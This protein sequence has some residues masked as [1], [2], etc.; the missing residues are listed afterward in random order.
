MMPVFISALEF[1]GLP[2]EDEDEDLSE[3]ENLQLEFE[4]ES[5]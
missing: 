1:L 4:D 2:M 3:F 5:S